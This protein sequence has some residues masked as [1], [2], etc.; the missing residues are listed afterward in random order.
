MNLIRYA[1]SLLSPAG[2]KGR[3]SIFIFHR[4][5]PEPDLLL[6][7]EPDAERFNELLGWIKSWFNV[8]P[9][10]QAITYLRQGS[11]PERAAAI[12]FDD[13]YAD[14]RTVALPLLL[15]HKLTATFFIATGFIDGG[16]MWNDTVIES[17]RKCAGLS[18]DLTPIG[19]KQYDVGSVP[20]KKITIA[21]IL[22]EIKYRSITDRIKLSNQIALLA[23]TEPRSDLMMTSRQ[24][25]E[26][27]D[28]G[29]QI[30]AHTVNHPILAS[31][32]FA[33]VREEILESKMFLEKLIGERI[34]LFAYPNGKPGIDYLPEHVS[35]V[36][37]LGFDAAVST[38]AGSAVV[39]GDYYQIPRFT[40]WDRTKFRFGMRLI[41]NFRRSCT[42]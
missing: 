21:A 20:E 37:K 13:G 12:T 10:D 3:L 9:L 28:A 35:L 36:K 31:I 25:I 39:S 14:N 6:S 11:L 16:R 17:V 26:M 15:R 8:I 41:Q 5:L 18:L 7:D 1:Y 42:K 34:G 32:D 19:L 2:N 24:V 22:S 23:K 33:V 38:S 29:M 27:H 40:P 4:I 30:G